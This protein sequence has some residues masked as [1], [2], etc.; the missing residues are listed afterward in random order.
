MRF[1]LDESVDLRLAPY[2]RNLGHDV[3]VV[4]QDY[5]PSL[6]DHRI[7]AIAHQEQRVLITNDKDFGELVF[8]KQQPHFGVILFRL[9]TFEL[10][11]TLNRLSY[12][13]TQ[14]NNQLDRFLVVTRQR[15]RVRGD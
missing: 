10:T 9:G 14:C 2:L 6:P 8:V 5:Q 1:L 4:T 13:L 3:T 15:V 11:P 12:V 7:L